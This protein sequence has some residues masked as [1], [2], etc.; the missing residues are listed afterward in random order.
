MAL[1]AAVAILLLAAG[2]RLHGAASRPV[3]TD[4]GFAAWA[5]SA[6]SVGEMLDRVEAW[7]RHPPLTYFVLYAWREV[8]GESRLALRFWS[9][10]TGLLSAALVYRLGA[11]WFGARAGRI[12]LLLFA[13]LDLP[14]YYAQEVRHYSWLVLSACLM[15]LLFLRALRHP[16]RGRLIAYG[17]SIVFMLYSLYLGVLVVAVHGVVGL[18][19]WRG[20]RRDKAA[21]AVTW[22]AAGAAFVPW[23]IVLAGQFDRG[24]N[25]VN[26]GI[27]GFPG[28][29]AT[30]WPALRR[31]MELVFGGQWALT[32][33]AALFGL[34][35]L[36]RTRARSVQWAA[37]LTVAL[38]GIGLL[39]FM[40]AANE[41]F[42]VLSARTLVFLTPF[43]M[44]T[45]AHG[46]GS[47]DRRAGAILAGAFALVMLVTPQTIQPRL[48]SD[49]T[50][51]AVAAAYSP[52]D[53][54]ILETG[55]DDNAF[56][57]ELS[58]ALPDG[59]QIIRTLPWVGNPLTAEPVIPHVADAIAAHRR[60]W[61]VQW[62]QPSAVIPTIEGESS[63]FRRV[64]TLEISTGDEYAREYPA[65]PLVTAAL[66][67]RPDLAR[68]PVV[69]GDLFALRDVVL[70]E[71]A[72][73]G[74]LLH[75]D[76][77][78]EAAQPPTLDYSVGVFLMN[79]EGATVADHQGPPGETPTTAWTVGDPVFDRHTLALPPDLPPGAYTVAVNVYWYGDMQPLDAGGQTLVAVGEVAV[80]D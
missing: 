27:G 14:V 15:T 50:A 69:F 17:L 35:A 19:V 41:W 32:V 3:W 66:F 80:R 49:W 58:L 77:W 71:T 48:R 37:R 31:V 73:A 63:D 34:G 56:Q 54:V 13:V 24:Y 47:L 64:R 43:V 42:G 20:S 29:L 39:V 76:L 8:A 57:Y 40:I 78:W 16:S 60:V 2:A 44:L 68:E 25:S 74:D 61:V 52:G 9:I 65:T 26:E 22:I 75:V 79:A 4:E 55:W 12:A 45:A 51:Q 21:L 33:G 11:D 70:P 59:A 23:L 62:L 72:Q 7:D 10:L 5:S 28:S 6:P 53:L 30:T 1:W 18:F 67:E 46:L 38:A 36:I